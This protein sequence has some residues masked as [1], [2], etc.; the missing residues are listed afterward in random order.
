MYFTTPPTN[1]WMFF[2]CVFVLSML[3]LLHYIVWNIYL[4]SQE[5]DFS[6]MFPCI[7]FSV[8][9]FEETTKHEALPVKILRKWTNVAPGKGSHVPFQKNFQANMFQG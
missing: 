7:F 5:V 3:H 1:S 6:M 2:F 4:T 8:K 9:L